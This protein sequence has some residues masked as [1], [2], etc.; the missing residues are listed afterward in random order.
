MPTPQE[1][2]NEI[3]NGPLKDDLLGSWANGDDNYTAQVLNTKNKRGPIPIVELSAYCATEGI[4]GA[5]RALL[6]IPIGSEIAP[7]VL[8]TLQ[9]KTLL[10]TVETLLVTDFRMSTADTDDPKFVMAYQGLISLGVMTQDQCDAIIAL[11]NNRMSR[12]EEAFNEIGINIS[13]MQ[14]GEARNLSN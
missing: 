14:V 8:M 12:A 11:G 7:S 4:T 9:I 10:Y 6:E 2:R 1:L 3:L 13:P 5:V